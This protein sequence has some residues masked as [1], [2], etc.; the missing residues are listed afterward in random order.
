[1]VSDKII[2]IGAGPAGMACS[3]TLAEAGRP[4]LIIEK[5]G[6]PG[7]LC[8]T[9]NFH[10]YLF[11][12]G[13]HRFISRSEEITRLW[14]NTMGEDML[15]VRRLSRIYYRKRYFKY[16]LSFFDT[17]WNLG[18]VESTRGIFS[19]LRCKNTKPGDNS[20]FEG[21]IINH[22]GR[23]LYDIFFKTYTEKVWAVPCNNISADWA[24]Q[25]IRGLSL[26]VALKK[27]L[28]QTNDAPKTLAEE[29]LY[30][31]TGPGEFY[32]RLKDLIS[33]DGGQFMFGRQLAGIKHDG[34]KILSITVQN[35]AD[36]K[37][38]ELPVDYLFSSIPLPTLVKILSPAAPADVIDSAN[39][40]YFRDFLIVNIILDKEDT[41]PDQWI[42]VHSPEV[43]L[44]RIQNYKNWSSAMVPDINKTSL[45]IEYFCSRNDILWNMSDVDLIHYAVGELEKIGIV[46][47]RYLINGFVIRYPN[48]YPVYSLD[49]RKD[50]DIIQRYLS[51]F[52]NLQTIGR[53]GLF[54]Y[55]NSDH[56][57]LTGIYAAGNFLG[58]GPHNIWDINP[59]QE[60]LES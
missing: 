19:Y 46:S 35:L 59:D 21:W 42:Y 1:M 10:G 33:A 30:P 58:E 25:R 38:E 3:Y 23:R 4:S 6:A 36:N 37:K 2:I 34:G 43:K 20:T 28:F 18:L 56:A 47:R 7:G 50:V 29:F 51:G 27:A 24:K 14:H 53:A 49:Y 44:G 54:H 41:F 39:N 15:H 11:D 31:R 9:V 5:E 45:G 40:L 8:K 60:Y 16:P 48:V 57:L 52:G 22:F 13:G 55:D 17:F 12:I 32:K 26:K